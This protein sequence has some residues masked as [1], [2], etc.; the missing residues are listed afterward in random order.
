MVETLFPEE[1]IQTLAPVLTVPA[2]VNTFVA[3]E[4]I[5]LLT[6]LNEHPLPMERQA[7]LPEEILLEFMLPVDVPDKV[8]AIVLTA[9]VSILQF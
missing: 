8:M 7:A 9:E 2:P 5:R 4:L 6:G 3:L 1:F